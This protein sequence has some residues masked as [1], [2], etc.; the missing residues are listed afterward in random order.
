[1]RNTLIL[2]VLISI[3]L[4]TPVLADG[5][6]GDQRY[7]SDHRQDKRDHRAYANHDRNQKYD[8][9][10]KRMKTLRKELRQE[11]RE[12]RRLERR[13]IRRSQRVARYYDYRR[14]Y[15]APIVVAPRRDFRPLLSPSI[16]VRIPLNW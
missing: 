8:H 15:R 13:D 7:S 2:M 5:R 1:M 6:H 12:N 16:V 14:P 9:F 10:Q 3:G 11:R 4:A